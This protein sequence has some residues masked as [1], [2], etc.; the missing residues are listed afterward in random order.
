MTIGIQGSWGTGKTSL[1]NMIEDQIEL[2]NK[3]KNFVHI[4]INAWEHSLLSRPEET[5]FKIV[6]DI[7][8]NIPGI[9][10][11]IKDHSKSLLKQATRLGAASMGAAIS[12]IAEDLLTSEN[13]IR[14]LK[15]D[16]EKTLL[17]APF[18]K[19]IIY[20]DDL[21]RINP[22]DAVAILELLKNIFDLKNVFLF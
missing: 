8:K 10:K 16:V 6:N 21:D 20:I 22:P 7:L 19:A 17:S 13:T 9:N 11:G 14:D 3:S 1:L 18:E 12:N 4:K 5:L 15:K 2:D